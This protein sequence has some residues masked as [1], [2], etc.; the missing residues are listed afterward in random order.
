[1]NPFLSGRQKADTILPSDQPEIS[2]VFIDTI[3]KLVA[4]NF[5]LYFTCKTKSAQVFDVNKRLIAVIIRLLGVL[6]QKEILMGIT[7]DLYGK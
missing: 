2:S 6:A 5:Y 7:C 3:E 4:T 1:M